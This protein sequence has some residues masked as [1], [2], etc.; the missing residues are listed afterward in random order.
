MVLPSFRAR[1]LAWAFVF[2]DPSPMYFS[3]LDEF[4]HDSPFVSRKRPR[5]N[6]SPVFGL[7][8]F[9]M[10]TTTEEVQFIGRLLVQRYYISYR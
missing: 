10:P 3:Y 5:H 8:G 6:T 4:G 1:A 2:L 7:A 9:V